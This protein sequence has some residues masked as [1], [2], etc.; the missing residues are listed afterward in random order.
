MMTR[1]SALAAIVS[2]SFPAAGTAVAANG[3]PLEYRAEL[4]A[5]APAARLIVRDVVWRCDGAACVAPAANSRP[6]LVCAALARQ[7]GAL[8]SFAVEGRALAAEELEKCNAR[9]R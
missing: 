2:A 6:A 3:L 9:A 5:P 8:R 1:F 7:A 4:A